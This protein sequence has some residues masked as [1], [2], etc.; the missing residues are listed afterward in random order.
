[1][2]FQHDLH[3]HTHCS[4]DS[5]CASID[6]IM[7]AG[8]KMGYRHF[9]ISDH[10]HTHFN[11]PDIEVA[12]KEFMETE[13]PANFHFGLEITC[14]TQWECEKIARRDYTS[15]FTYILNGTP[16]RTITPIDGVMYGG[17]PDGPLYLDITREEME[18]LG[19][20]YIIGGVHKP[21]YTRQ[22]PRP[23]IDD[24]FNQ[25]CFM[26]ADD[27]IDIIAH[28][29]WAFPF[30]S[31][32]AILSG[33]TQD[34]NYDSYRMIPQEYWDELARRFVQ[35]GKLAELNSGFLLSRDNMPEEI[36]SFYLEKMTEWKEKGVK[37]SFGSDLHRSEYQYEDV[38]RFE[39]LLKSFGFAEK[40]FGLPVKLQTGYDSK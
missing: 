2:L 17:P 6:K 21:N 31:S 35:S 19:I 9:G 23:M 15:C 40:D 16:F 20:E 8:K 26:L 10:L 12:G 4:C 13:R 34:Q 30:W 38:Y 28:P 3:I 18:R 36:L 11:L 29:W 25:M 27:R 1:M 24:Y 5:A 33:N 14:A 7:E 32:Y 39:E 37:F 22:E